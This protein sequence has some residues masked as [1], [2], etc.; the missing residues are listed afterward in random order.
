MVT[1]ENVSLTRTEAEMRASLIRS[2]E[3]AVELD[4]AQGPDR[5][6]FAVRLEFLGTP[7]AKTFIDAQVD[8]V[9]GINW[10][11]APLDLG[12]YA[13][14]RIELPPLEASNVLEV[15]GSSPYHRT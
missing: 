1:V 9:D 11:G 15:S 10:Q 4:L 3:Y 13:G 14:Q 2:C 7:G 12:A 5:Y 6:R 8:R